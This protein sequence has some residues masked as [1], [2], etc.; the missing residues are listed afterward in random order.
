MADEIY[1]HLENNVILLEEQTSCHRSSIGTKNQLLFDKV[2]MKNC[3]GWKFGLT[4]AWV[5]YLK[6]YDMVPMYMCR[7][8]KNISYFLRVWGAGK[9]F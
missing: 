9:Q 1:H 7:V 2:V 3:K 8:A 6:A 4:I 5:D